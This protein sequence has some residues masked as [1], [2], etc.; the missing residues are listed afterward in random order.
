MGWA[1]TVATSMLGEEKKEEWVSTGEM[2]GAQLKARASEVGR[3]GCQYQQWI[4]QQSQPMLQRLRSGSK[5]LL[6]SLASEGAYSSVVDRGEIDRRDRE[7]AE[8]MAALEAQRAEEEKVLLGSLEALE[9]QELEADRALWEQQQAAEA[10]RQQ[11][12]ANTAQSKIE[13]FEAQQRQ[14][15]EAREYEHSARRA[16]LKERLAHR[17]LKRLEEQRMLAEAQSKREL[18]AW[19]LTQAVGDEVSLAQAQEQAQEVEAEAQRANDERR[20]LEAELD[21]ANS[22]Q[23]ASKILQEHAAEELKRQDA[24]QVAQQRQRD[25]LEQRIQ[26]RQRK[27]AAERKEKAAAEREAVMKDFNKLMARGEPLSDKGVRMFAAI[28]EVTALLEQSLLENPS[29]EYPR[30]I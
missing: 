23:A 24:V 2:L 30:V 9:Q 16:A 29:L 28:Q 20:A 5:Q 7:M 18:E 1:S 3:W 12:D 17:K 15:E 27:R 4:A 6:V 21:S 14:H 13:N 22:Q 8:V 25:E 26:E 11:Q 19:M 10:R